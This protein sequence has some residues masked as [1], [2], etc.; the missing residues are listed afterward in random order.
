MAKASSD[1]LPVILLLTHV[2]ATRVL[3]KQ[4]FNEEYF[5]LEVDSPQEVLEK[6]ASTKLEV[7]ILDEKTPFALDELCKKIRLHPGAKELPILI[8]SNNLKR[9]HLK[10]LVTAGANDFLHEPLDQEA[11]HDR[12]ESVIKKYSLQQKLSPLAKGLAQVASPI[13]EKK[14]CSSR[15]SVKDQALQ[16][17]RK[18]LESKQAI[19][20]LMINIDQM[21]KVLTRWGETAAEELSEAL[22][23]HLTQHSRP[24]DICLKVARDRFALVLPKT[25][26]IAAKLMAE[27]LEETFPYTKF[28][29]HKGS[30]KLNVSIGVVS[31]AEND[32][33]SQNAYDYLEKML[34]TGEHYLEKAK[35]IGQRIVSS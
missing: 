30:V 15:V 21:P 13:S 27:S 28:T 26:H 8:I 34:Q 35:T 17:V 20:L 33:S 6:V 22:E 14:L 9:S 31:L 32:P 4:T 29:T 2:N 10:E 3:L 1:K 24:Q 11:I 12:I 18:A 25:S 7:I 19:S 5:I 23:L 16:E